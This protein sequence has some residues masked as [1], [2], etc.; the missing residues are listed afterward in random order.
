MNWFQQNR[1]LGTFLIIVGVCTLAAGYFLFHAKSGSEEA[2]TQFNEAAAERSRLERLD[3]YPK[4]ANVV[5]MKKHLQNYAQS[6]DKLK[7]DL[8]T[9]MLPAP[10]LA[11]NEFQSRLRQAMTAVADKARTNRVKL[12]ENFALGFDEFTAALPS[13]AAAPLLGQELAQVELLL[14][15]IIEARVDGIT[16][17]VRAPLPEERGPATIPTPAAGRKPAPAA[18]PAAGTKMLERGILDV[19]F[20]STPSAAR[21]ILN[22]LASSNQQFYITRTVH[23]KNEKDKGPARELPAAGAS[24]TPVAAATPGKPVPGAA[25]SFIVGNEHIETSARIELVRFTF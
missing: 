19:T 5:E 16:A 12:P 20:D 22:Q 2:L 13:T 9:R 18:T 23:I 7:G 14:N 10:P 6:L 21:K 4:E 24:A 11:P 25:L 17:L 8:K 1:W 3:P 15:M